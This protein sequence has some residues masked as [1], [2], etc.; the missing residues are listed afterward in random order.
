MS[1]IFSIRE[2]LQFAVEKEHESQELYQALAAQVSNPD[3]KSLFKKFVIQEKKHEKLYAAM[4]ANVKEEQPIN[5]LNEYMSYMRELIN[6][7][8]K[9]S[10][11]PSIMPMED[12]HELL[13]YAVLR[14]KESVLFYVGLRD[15]ISAPYQEQVDAIMKEEVKHIMML[16]DLKKAI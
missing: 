15:Y 14:E 7:S 5:D 4:L 8:H 1:K 12:L 3:A 2:I 16:S 13:D 10:G 11:M 6:A 9:E